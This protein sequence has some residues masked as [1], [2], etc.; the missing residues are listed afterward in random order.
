MK[1]KNKYIKVD[2]GA[3]ETIRRSFEIVNEGLNKMAEKTDR[4]LDDSHDCSG[5]KGHCP[6]CF[7][8]HRKGH[9]EGKYTVC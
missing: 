2:V 1:T 5:E 7:Y 9:Y 6:I 4:A 3:L 8:L